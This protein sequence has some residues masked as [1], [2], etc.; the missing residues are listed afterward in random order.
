MIHWELS[1][2]LDDDSLTDEPTD[3]DHFR[4]R[5]EFGLSV[6]PYVLAAMLL[7]HAVATVCQWSAA[8][9][10]GRLRQLSSGFA[11][12]PSP[13]VR[14]SPAPTAVA[15]TRGHVDAPDYIRFRSDDG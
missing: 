8:A 9:L 7:A 12:T 6:P 13:A 1:T 14:S 5:R 15:T 10:R 3:P 4:L 2:L 11:T